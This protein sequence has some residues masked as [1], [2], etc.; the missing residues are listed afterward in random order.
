VISRTRDEKRET[1]TRCTTDSEKLHTCAHAHAHAYSSFENPVQTVLD[2]IR[3]GQRSIPSAI[4]WYTNGYAIVAARSVSRPHYAPHLRFLRERSG[5]RCVPN[6]RYACL[7]SRPMTAVDQRSSRGG[8][9]DSEL[10]RADASVGPE[11]AHWSGRAERGR[12]L[13]RGAM[14]R[15]C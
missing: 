10:G 5:A 14:A 4:T 15:G 3:R 9:D 1:C 7:T 12:H 8:R 6:P 13:R 2:A 11:S